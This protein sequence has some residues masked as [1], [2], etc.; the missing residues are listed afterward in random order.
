MPWNELKSKTH[1]TGYLLSGD[2]LKEAINS[3]GDLQGVN[4]GESL[5]VYP[6]ELPGR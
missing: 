2:Y 4:A 3:V 1:T 5:Q 6:Q